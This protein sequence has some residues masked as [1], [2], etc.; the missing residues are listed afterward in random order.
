MDSYSAGT[1]VSARVFLSIEG[2]AHRF[3]VECLAAESASICA[4]IRNA[5][6]RR[7]CFVAISNL[8]RWRE[9]RNLTLEAI[10]PVPTVLD[11]SQVDTKPAEPTDPIRIR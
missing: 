10:Q 5:N 11:S 7:A 9:Q 8:S 4:S 1:P 2:T 3:A 6:T